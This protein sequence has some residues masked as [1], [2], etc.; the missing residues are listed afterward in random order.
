MIP[1]NRQL[2]ARAI[3][4]SLTE[5]HLLP[6]PAATTGLGRIS[7]V[8]SYVLPASF[9]RFAGQF[10]KELRPRCITDALGQTTIM[11]EI[12]HPDVLDSD[13]TILVDDAS[14]FLVSEVIAPKSD[15]F[16]NTCDL[17]AM[18]LWPL[19]A[20]FKSAGLALHLSQRF[21]LFPEKFGS[22]NSLAI[23]EDCERL[24]PDINASLF[25]R[26]RE[27]LWFDFYGKRHV[28]FIGS[29]TPDSAG[30]D[31]ALN[32]AMILHL[33]VADLG[34]FQSTGIGD[35]ESTLGLRKSKRIVAATASKPWI[36]RSALP[37]LKP[38]KIF[39][40]CEINPYRHILQD[41]RMHGLERRAHNR[42]QG[43]K[44]GVLIIIAEMLACPIKSIS[45]LLQEVVVKP[46]ALSERLFQK[47]RLFACWI[48][49][50]LK[51]FEH[52][53]SLAQNGEIWT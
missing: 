8:Y 24:Q 27:A 18:F 2:T 10:R 30:L 17:L 35:P 13:D 41:L 22:F 52:V 53:I 34:Q 19:L 40:E 20:F 39:F 45:A 46:A 26:L 9:F 4:N 32:G 7:W 33:D 5:R 14:R 23:R 36:S 31:H 28:P 15:T 38:T 25:T 16:V 44:L 50:I 3:E 1:I 37:R 42:L 48:Y 43:R 29:R 11:Q 21:F 12:V 51:F 49:S 47:A 6:M